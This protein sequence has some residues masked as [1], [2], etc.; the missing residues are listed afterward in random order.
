MQQMT[1]SV[2][3][4]SAVPF[5]CMLAVVSGPARCTQWAPHYDHQP[6]ILIQLYGIKR[7]TRQ[8]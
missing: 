5:Q 8:A 7:V 2:V 4:N 1:L 3:P 6:N